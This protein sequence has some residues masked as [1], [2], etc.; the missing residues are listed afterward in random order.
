VFDPSEDSS[1]GNGVSLD[2]VELTYILSFLREQDNAVILKAE[3][4]GSILE[5]A[6]ILSNSNLV[7]LDGGIVCSRLT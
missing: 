7:S 6:D 4:Q 3:L 2:G 1:Q 5:K